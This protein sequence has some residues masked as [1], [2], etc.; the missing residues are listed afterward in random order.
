MQQYSYKQRQNLTANLNMR[1][2]MTQRNTRPVSRVNFEAEDADSLNDDLVSFE[3]KIKY[4]KNLAV[5]QK[6]PN[7]EL[8][9][10]FNPQNFGANNRQLTQ[11][12]STRA[13]SLRSHVKT[14][15][16]RK[17]RTNEPSSDLMSGSLNERT[18]RQS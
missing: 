3:S 2:P 9:R 18:Y 12:T 15:V 14:T 6:Y 16:P 1:V 11:L 13:G 8:K 17:H 10:C 7:I 5:V 4:Q